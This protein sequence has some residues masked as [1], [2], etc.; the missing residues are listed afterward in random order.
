MVTLVTVLRFVVGLALVLYFAE[1][2]V[3]GATGTARRWGVS[4]FLVSVVFI[5]VALMRS[6]LMPI[7]YRSS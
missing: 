5:G 1:K 4:A 6:I 7:M 3:D 2:L